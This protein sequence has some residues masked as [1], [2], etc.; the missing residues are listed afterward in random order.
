MKCMET[1]KYEVYLKRHFKV[2]RIYQISAVTLILIRESLEI[3][4]NKP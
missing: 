4:N 2:S 3:A 1:R